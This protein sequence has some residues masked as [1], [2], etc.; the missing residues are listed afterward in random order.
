MSEN[1]V[2]FKPAQ[3]VVWLKHKFPEGVGATD[4]PNDK[5]IKTKFS[6]LKR[7]FKDASEA[8]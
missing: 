2:G 8:I 5:Q 1:G 7:A 6:A 3:A 4:F